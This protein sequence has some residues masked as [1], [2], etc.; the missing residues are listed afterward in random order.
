MWWRK[1]D[2]DE[3][4]AQVFIRMHSGETSPA[5]RDYFD[6]WCLD[7]PG[8]LEAYYELEDL[9]EQA[10][11]YATRLSAEE[12]ADRLRSS[13]SLRNTGSWRYPTTREM[14]LWAAAG[15]VI[16]TAMFIIMPPFSGTD[17]VQYQAG[18]GEQLVVNLDDGS[19][20]QL[21]SL[22]RIEVR[23][24]ERRRIVMLSEGEALFMVARDPDRKFLVRTNRGRVEALGTRFNVQS[25]PDDLIV[26]VLQGTVLVSTEDA[27]PE[28]VQTEIAT[29]GEQVL[30]PRAGQIRR[31]TTPKLEQ[32][33]AWSEGK[34][35]FT[36]EPLYEAIDRVNRQ[37]KH[38]LSLKEPRLRE[39]VIYGVFNAGDTRGF[40]S[41]LEQAYPIRSVEISGTTTVLLYRELRED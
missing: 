24:D 1:N 29:V 25:A 17:S 30:V 22:S 8:R 4:T 7:N 6:R 21:N 2:I 12:I 28:H 5:D 3:D 38:T 35:I 16:A 34:L 27:V 32:V 11:E 13:G 39:L 9:W 18:R 36:G 15:L 20:V 33:I 41:A 10:G 31:R 37:S 19:S 14:G 26:T 40:V 23:F